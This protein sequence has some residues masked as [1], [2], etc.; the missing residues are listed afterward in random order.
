[1]VLGGYWWLL[2]GLLI[3]FV[4]G[5][6]DFG[7]FGVVPAEDLRFFFG[8]TVFEMLNE[9]GLLAGF[10]WLFELLVIVFAFGLSKKLLA[11]MFQFV[12]CFGMVF[13]W[14]AEGFKMVYG[15]LLKEWFF[16]CCQV[17]PRHTYY[18]V[19]DTHFWI[20]KV[21]YGFLAFLL[22]VLLVKPRN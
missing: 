16:C 17:I 14:F 15:G 4:E 18:N 12:P 19:N 3:V 6:W 10:S 20:E 5:V 8:F 7:K 21:G 2:Y 13:K 1:M 11:D 9:F 22:L